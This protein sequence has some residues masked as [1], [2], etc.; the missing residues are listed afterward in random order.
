MQLPM[1]YE[2]HI[3]L[4]CS[5]KQQGN[6]RL[7]EQIAYHLSVSITDDLYVP[8]KFNNTTC[9]LA[10]ARYILIH[11]MKQIGLIT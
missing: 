5:L 7:A 8:V 11:S 1:T 10:S 9:A 4:M 6:I 2:Q 3:A